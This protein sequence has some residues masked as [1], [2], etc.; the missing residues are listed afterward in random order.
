MKFLKL[1]NVSIDY[2]YQV[3]LTNG[4]SQ[5]TNQGLLAG[6]INSAF[7]GIYSGPG[8]QQYQNAQQSQ[9]GSNYN[10]QQQLGINQ[11]IY[12]QLHQSPM[13]SYIKKSVMIPIDNI[14]Y[15][16]EEKMNG[17]NT[18]IHFKTPFPNGDQ[19]L[20]PTY[21][22]HVEE[23]IDMIEKQIHT[24]QFNNKMDELLK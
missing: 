10:Q 9:Q 13:Q 18:I 6:G 7:G 24:Q 17:N 11:S 14:N 8:T 12:N 1:T 20:G 5:I 19:F 2:N 16:I 3:H 22:L 15:F 21:T 4:S 23:T